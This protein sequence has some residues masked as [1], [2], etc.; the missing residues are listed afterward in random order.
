[1]KVAQY[2]RLPLISYDHVGNPLSDMG[3][4]G[5]DSM[6][7]NCRATYVGS[8]AC[9]CPSHLTGSTP[10][11]YVRPREIASGRAHP[12]PAGHPAHP[13]AA[14]ASPAMVSGEQGAV[15][16]AAFVRHA[17]KSILL[18]LWSPRTCCA[19]Q[20]ANARNLRDRISLSANHR[21]RGGQER[22][23]PG[24]CICGQRVFLFLPPWSWDAQ[25]LCKDQ[26]V[27]GLEQLTPQTG[28]SGPWPRYRPKPTTLAGPASPGQARPRLGDTKFIF[29]FC[30]VSKPLVV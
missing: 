4:A 5:R 29:E 26:R 16:V 8:F 17:Y 14:P 11:A 19:T 23:G 20:A 3:K 12:H 1:M 21:I 22:A 2:H 13:H 28:R 25:L 6:L 9:H 18:V 24:C 10:M 7:R 27:S 30:D 15:A